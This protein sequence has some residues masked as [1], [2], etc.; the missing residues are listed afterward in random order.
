MGQIIGKNTLTGAPTSASGTTNKLLYGTGQEAV[1]S[2]N[3]K[4]IGVYIGWGGKSANPTGNPVGEV[5]LFDVTSG[6]YE[7]APKLFSVAY[8]FSNASLSGAQWIY[9]PLNVDLSAHAGKSLAP[10]F[11]APSAGN[12]FDVLIETAAGANRKNGSATQTTLQATLGSGAVSSNQAWALYFETET[13]GP[14]LVLDSVLPASQNNAGQFTAIFSGNASSGTVDLIADGLTIAQDIVS[15]SYSAGTNKTTVVTNVVQA[16][17]PFGAATIRYTTSAVFTSAVTVVP[18][19][20]N[21]KIDIASP[22]N[23]A[24]YIFEQLETGNYLDVTQVEFTDSPNTTVSSSGVITQTSVNAF[25]ARARDGADK[26]W[27]TFS[28]ISPYL[29]Q[30]FLAIGSGGIGTG[31]G[32]TVEYLP[33]LPMQVSYVASGGLALSGSALIEK[34]RAF[35]SSGLIAI[36]GSAQVFCSAAASYSYL[37]AGG[38]SIAGSAECLFSAAGNAA[39]RLDRPSQVFDAIVNTLTVAIA[40]GNQKN[41]KICDYEEWGPAQH[42][43]RQILIEFGDLESDVGQNDGRHGQWQEIIIYPLISVA[44]PRAA[45]EANN[46]ASAIARKILGQ[47]WGLPSRLIEAPERITARS[48]FFVKQKDVFSY[49]AW[50]VR[51]WQLIKYG[52]D[53][54]PGDE[55]DEAFFALAINPSNPDDPEEYQDVWPTR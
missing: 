54:W 19:N 50:E 12:A 27:S 13:I 52:D 46:L 26:T 17:I 45:R 47:R 31:G 38:I 29:P 25:Q 10:G 33:V 40:G 1:L 39:A 44:V 2:A 3:Q 8:S 15:W 6:N 23:G 53:Q 42:A 14:S 32:A 35:F 24:G 5:G 11:S 41:I 16:G 36:S 43:D 22:Q 51:F 55:G 4:L 28:A 34:T 20:G 37:G 21:A 30:E 7:T 18:I 48:A 49:E 9:I